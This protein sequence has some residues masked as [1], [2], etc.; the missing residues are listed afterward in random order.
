MFH[1]VK[2]G[3][4]DS[5][6][7]LN[8][9]GDNQKNAGRESEMAATLKKW[10]DKVNEVD[11]EPKVE[12][13]NK[14]IREKKDD[15]SYTKTREEMVEQ[16][17]HGSEVKNILSSIAGYSHFT[18]YRLD[19]IT[20]LAVLPSSPSNESREERTPDIHHPEIRI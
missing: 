20:R 11:T 17:G 19:R 5:L 15:I 9:D 13:K 12:R 14:K 18:P 4:A 7:S 1:L 6:P 8:S 2:I 16:V 10:K 3:K